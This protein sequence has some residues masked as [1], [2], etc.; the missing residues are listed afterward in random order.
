MRKIE[1]WRIRRKMSDAS[2]VWDLLNLQRTIALC[3]GCA[4]HKMPWRWQ[5]KLHYAELTVLHG[6]GRCDYCRQE[7]LVSLYQSTDT[8]F[9]AAMERDHHLI[10]QIQERELRITDRRRVH[11]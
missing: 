11:I 6:S 2:W 7:D 1:M 5:A 4:T 9:W 3:K 8:P 10:A